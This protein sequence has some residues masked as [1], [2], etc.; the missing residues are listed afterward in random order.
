MDAMQAI[1]VAAMLAAATFGVQVA[2][3]FWAG[4]RAIREL[5]GVGGPGN[6]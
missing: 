2:V 3:E 4:E 6:R 5:D 1:S